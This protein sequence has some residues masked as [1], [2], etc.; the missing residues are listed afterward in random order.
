MRSSFSV[1]RSL[2][3]MTTKEKGE[4]AQLSVREAPISK[5]ATAYT[6]TNT[7]NQVVANDT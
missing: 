3:E 2:P 6:S 5:P 7:R 1:E 4:E